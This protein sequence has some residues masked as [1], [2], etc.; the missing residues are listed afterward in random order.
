[1]PASALAEAA[2][3]DNFS[4]LL[5]FSG[6]PAQLYAYG[7]NFGGTANAMELISLIQSTIAPLH[8]DVNDGPGHIHYYA[9]VGVL[10]IRAGMDVHGEVGDLLQQLRDQQ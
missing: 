10:V 6:G 9:P 1:L 2:L 3:A 4:T 7:W 5:Q 8:W